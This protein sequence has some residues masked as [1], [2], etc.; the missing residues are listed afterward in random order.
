MLLMKWYE[1]FLAEFT[2]SGKCKPEQDI[3]RGLLSCFSLFF[4]E[5]FHLDIL[6]SRR[7]TQQSD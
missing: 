1:S 3:Q 6:G 5:F 4:Q 7:P 2:V